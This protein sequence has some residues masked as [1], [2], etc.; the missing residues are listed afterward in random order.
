MKRFAAALCAL[1]FTVAL[2]GAAL[3][4]CPA[5]ASAKPQTSTSTQGS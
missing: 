3:A 4:D 1:S 5:H 2:S